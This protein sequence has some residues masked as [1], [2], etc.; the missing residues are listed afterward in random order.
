LQGVAEEQ[1]GPHALQGEQVFFFGCL[2]VASGE[3]LSH[4]EPQK[5]DN[6]CKVDFCYNIDGPNNNI[7]CKTSSS[8]QLLIRLNAHQ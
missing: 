1:N 6:A 4:E 8:V 5:I 2:F 3:F 7:T